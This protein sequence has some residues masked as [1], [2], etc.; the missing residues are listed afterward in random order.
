[1]LKRKDAPQRWLLRGSLIVPILLYLAG[2]AWSYEHYGTL[3]YVTATGSDV[4]ANT[5][6]GSLEFEWTT[7][8]VFNLDDRGW[9][10]RHVMREASKRRI[11][12]VSEDGMLCGF[13]WRTQTECGATLRAVAVPYYALLLPLALSLVLVWR[14]TRRP[15]DGGAFPVERAAATKDGA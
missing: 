4:G 7:P 1:M 10:F 2:W 12:V 9:N 15:R 6:R 5:D 14:K 3:Y 13:G 11:V 8:G